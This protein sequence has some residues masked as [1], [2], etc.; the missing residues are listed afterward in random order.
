[1]AINCFSIYKK[2]TTAAKTA[3]LF[4]LL[5]SINTLLI[6]QSHTHPGTPQNTTNQEEPS[7]SLE[8]N[9]TVEPCGFQ[10]VLNQL[11]QQYPG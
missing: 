5:T 2:I 1:M 6:A 9:P 7:P 3:S 4:F 11:E 8:L 10:Q